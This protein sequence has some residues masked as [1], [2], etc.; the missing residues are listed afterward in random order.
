MDT[1]KEFDLF[2]TRILNPDKGL[3]Y[4]IAEEGLSFQNTQLQDKDF[5]KSTKKVQEI[6]SDENGNFKDA[7]FDAFYNQISLEFSYLSQIDSAS[8][9]FDTYEKSEADFITPFGRRKEKTMEVSKVTNPLEQTYNLAG[10]D[11]WSTPELSAREAAQKNKVLKDDGTWTSKTLNDIGVGILSMPGIVYATY[12]TDGYHRDEFTGEIKAHHKGEFKT[13][14]FGKYY[15]EIASDGENLGKQFVTLSEVL[16]DDENWTNYLDIFDSDNREQDL[17]RTGVRAAATI[18]ATFIPVVGPTIVY[19]TAALEFA[20]ALPGLAKMVNG[21]VSDTQSAELNKWDNYMRK[22]SISQ[23]DESMERGFWAA[24]NIINML[25]DSFMQLTQQRAIANIPNKVFGVDARVEKLRKTAETQ[26]QAMSLFTGAE[27]TS[28]L[29]ATKEFQN[30]NALYEKTRKLSDV[31]SKVYLTTT[32]MQDT[33]NTARR[34]GLNQETSAYVTLLSLA[35]MY[36]LLQTDYFRGMLSNTPDYE[37]SQEMR[38]VGKAFATHMTDE[39]RGA[40]ILKEV[41]EEAVSGNKLPWYKELAKKA[42]NFFTGH[43]KEVST[44]K[45]GIVSGMLAEGVEELSEEVMQDSATQLARGLQMVK[46]TLT[47]RKYEDDYKW[48]DTDPLAR[49][50]ASFFGGALG[51]AVFKTADLLHFGRDAYRQWTNMLNSKQELGNKIIDYVSEGKTRELLKI[52]ENLQNSPLAS[53]EI[54]AITGQRTSDVEESINHVVFNNIKNSILTMDSFIRSEGIG[55]SRQ[56]L[57]TLELFKNLRVGVLKQEGIV[58]LM[59]NEYLRKM[60]DLLNL[61]GEKVSRENTLNDATLSNKDAIQKEVND[62]TKLISEK[63]AEIRDL[64]SGNSEKYIGMTMLKLNPAILNSILPST[65]DAIAQNRFNRNYDQLPTYLKSEVD[66]VIS[67]MKDGKFSDINLFKVWNVYRGITSDNEFKNKLAAV[68]NE[69]GDYS[70]QLTKNE[71]LM[72]VLLGGI[73]ENSD[74]LTV[75]DIKILAKI[76]DSGKFRTSKPIEVS[77]IDDLIYDGVIQNKLA[78]TEG[79][80][81]IAN[82]RAIIS[83]A[84]EK[85]KQDPTVYQKKQSEMSKDEVEESMY[86]SVFGD[87]KTFD[88]TLENLK[89]AAQKGLEDYTDG[90]VAE[91]YE[92][93]PLHEALNFVFA[94]LGIGEDFKVFEN[95]ESQLKNLEVLRHNYRL[96]PETRVQLDKIKT[97]IQAVKGIINGSDKNASAQYAGVIVGASNELNILFNDRHIAQSLAQINSNSAIELINEL[98]YL[99]ESIEALEKAD[100]ENA[101]QLISRDKK[102]FIERSKAKI[103]AIKNTF[104]D[105]DFTPQFDSQPPQMEVS[106]TG[107]E[108]DN[109]VELRQAIINFEQWFS[110][111]Y[112]E[113]ED[114]EDLVKFIVHKLCGDDTSVLE[115]DPGK[116]TGDNF[117]FEPADQFWYLLSLC[118]ENALNISE[119]YKNRVTDEAYD[120]CPFDMQEEVAVQAARLAVVPKDTRKLWVNS[121]NRTQDCGYA[122]NLSKLFG[123]AGVGK[124]DAIIPMIAK[125]TG[126]KLIISVNTEIQR[127]AMKQRFEGSAEIFL[128]SEILAQPD[129]FFEANKDALFILDESTNIEYDLLGEVRNSNNEVKNGDVDTLDKK[130]EKNNIVGIFLGDPTQTGKESNISHIVCPST[131]QMYDPVRAQFDILRQ[132]L[133]MLRDKFAANSEGN[134]VLLRAEPG[135]ALLYYLNE[136]TKTFIGHMYKNFST[137]NEKIAYVNEFMN[138]FGGNDKT[139][140]VYSSDASLN[141]ELEKISGVDVHSSVEAVQGS[142]WDYVICLDNLAF[143]ESAITTA[144]NVNTILSRAKY[145]TVLPAL[146]GIW[147]FANNESIFPPVEIGLTPEAINEFKKFKTNVLNRLSFGAH[148]TSSGSS[149]AGSGTSVPSSGIIPITIVPTPTPVD[150]QN[151]AISEGRATTDW[152]LKEED[153][154]T[155]YGFRSREEYYKVRYSLYRARVENNNELIPQKLKSGDFVFSVRSGLTTG[156]FTTFSNTHEFGK[157]VVNSGL[158]TFLAYVYKDS[159]GAEHIMHLGMVFTKNAFTPFDYEVS[160]MTTALNGDNRVV[161][162]YKIPSNIVFARGK[163][164]VDIKIDFMNS[165]EEKI[166]SQAATSCG[167]AMPL[168]Q[169]FYMSHAPLGHQLNAQMITASSNLEDIR[170]LYTEIHTKLQSALRNT[171]L[172]NWQE[173]VPLFK[174]ER[175][176]DA[177]TGTAPRGVP[178]L[179]HSYCAFLHSDPTQRSLVSLFNTYNAQLETLKNTLTTVRDELQNSN[180]DLKRVRGLA[181][182]LGHQMEHVSIISWDAAQCTTDRDWDKAFNVAFSDSNEHLPYKRA[183][184]QQIIEVLTRFELILN[185]STFGATN[186]S[187]YQ[188]KKVHKD[189]LKAFKDSHGRLFDA[190]ANFINNWDVDDL[191]SIDSGWISLKD[192]SEDIKKIYT[193][194]VTVGGKSMTLAE[195]LELSNE[196]VYKQK[197]SAS[198]RNSNAYLSTPIT[199]IYPKLIKFD[200]STFDPQQV[201]TPGRGTV[202][203]TNKVVYPS[204]IRIIGDSTAIKWEPYGQGTTSTTPNVPVDS[205]IQQQGT[206]EQSS[207]T[208]QLNTKEELLAWLENTNN[209][210]SSTLYEVVGDDDLEDIEYSREFIQVIQGI[211]ENGGQFNLDNAIAKLGA[212]PDPTESGILETLKETLQDCQ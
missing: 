138:A 58:E 206:T 51:G 83:R 15:T 94:R 26:A 119:E 123:L 175:S 93:G 5:Y 1:A 182:Q 141:T 21:L 45:F 147:K 70:S 194:P 196:W 134:E 80:Q 102:A 209:E 187:N 82:M 121:I 162:L 125:F 133:Q 171:A 84:A 18:A 27:L 2:A 6:F 77:D 41:A 64:I 24:E 43:V 212:N 131:L 159:L 176:G 22:F 50:S 62:L 88:T 20:K 53:K 31:I 30:I 165:G 109:A 54:S 68:E 28:A 48:L 108:E 122:H 183:V 140:M 204:P 72:G 170:E 17:F 69:I 184:I 148:S 197:S 101:G 73:F 10:F 150:P 114:P 97:L 98:D 137:N 85:Y 146:T 120:K 191:N 113:L 164:P 79:Q 136:E 86:L 205:V 47:G 46:A 124:S 96:A 211:V 87:V 112:S 111:F 11:E 107:S 103:Q 52:F 160:P 190:F 208:E 25:Q 130:F 89:T 200:S 156:S 201:P 174:Y 19:G 202:L 181:H 60:K 63:T 179:N 135:D 117:I 49:Y 13:D 161:G 195:I 104:L 144:K 100:R 57:E 61:H 193:A 8:F 115:K 188:F 154:H 155:K 157:N 173:Y 66:N 44:G 166:N 163:S 118:S 106:E 151:G 178:N 7:E 172:R 203:Y 99:S 75:Q 42:Q 207:S 92:A 126:K 192:F 95:V 139:I 145:G 39:V 59:H 74:D 153:D 65:Q 40:K 3:S 149:T 35:G 32:A 90:I 116:L 67:G 91:I 168:S 12:D 36:S 37:L 14:A 55:T 4:F 105:G 186:S 185:S 142:E 76:F 29:K 177:V 128:H 34:N 180:P 81:A 152:I 199:R 9:I 127:S 110:K 158:Y 129:S 16:T 23:S 33:F 143:S 78:S 198:V 38:A 189:K 167:M 56:K 169:T 210:V 71:Y 132:N